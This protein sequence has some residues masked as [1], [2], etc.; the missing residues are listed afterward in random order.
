MPTPTVISASRT[1][2]AAAAA[3]G[4]P[5]IS[6]GLWQNFGSDRPLDTQR[7]IILRAFDL[8][9][10]HFDLANNYGGHTLNTSDDPLGRLKHGP[11][12]GSAERNFGR[13]L[14]DDLRPYR[15]ELIISTKAGYD[16]WPGPY[17]D[18][19][20]RKYLLASLDQSLARMG[21]DYVDIFYS[22][23]V[24]PGH[25][26]G[27]DHG[28]AGHRGHL[29]PGAVCGD[30][31]LLRRADRAGGRHLAPARHAA[32]DPPAVLLDAQ[33][34]GRGRPAGHAG[35]R[36]RRLHRVLAARAGHAH[37]QIPGRRSQPGHAPARAAP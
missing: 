10:T 19:G 32:A 25:P 1:A 6:L 8:G 5:E 15:D 3:S 37:R 18:W 16:M 31:L 22:H 2:A 27:G 9:V 24:R 36:G 30:L 4:S 7:A 21:L 29:G 20:S 13:I 28:R 11:L 33:P 23:R 17:G 34:L 35:R 12:Y 26:A 14:R